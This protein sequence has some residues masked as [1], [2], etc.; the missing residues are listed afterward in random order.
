MTE[1]IVISNDLDGTRADRA[2]AVLCGVSR[3]A[4]RRSIDAGG[5]QRRGTIVS[6][7][8]KVFEGDVLDVALVTVEETV[9]PESSVEFAVAYEDDDVIVVDKPSGVVVH[10][11]A[12]RPSGTLANGLLSRYPEIG[13]LPPECRWGIV[14]RID[15]DTSGLLIVAKTADAFNHLQAAL[16]RREIKREYRALVGGQFSS[17]TG[18]IDAPIG[19]DPT[20][21]TRMAVIE[22]GRPARTHFQRLAEWDNADVSLAAVALETGRTHQIRV[23]MRSIGHPVVGDPVYGKK[24]SAAGDPGRTWLHAASLTFEHPSGSGPVTV[25]SNLPDD[26]VVSLAGLGDP[27]RGDVA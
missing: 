3:G 13:E 2:V 18:T 23:H 24:R 14:H 27:S 6:G 8:T 19:R 4:A 15:R 20:E 10:P 21:P 17:S 5:V 9:I 1:R 11:G 22:S 12:G 25:R 16:K 7:A 26:L